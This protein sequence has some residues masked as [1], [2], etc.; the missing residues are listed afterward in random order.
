M[1]DKLFATDGNVEGLILRVVLA[2]VI[3]PHGAQK[4]L[5]WFGG[6]GWKGTLGFFKSLGIP[7]VFGVAAMLTEFLGPI[8]LLVGFA[9]KPVAVI[10]AVNMIVAA[11][12]VHRKTGFFM[13]W[14]GAQKGEGF[15]YHILAVGLALA[16]MFQGGG[17]LSVDR[18]LLRA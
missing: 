18:L 11:V 7:T 6:Y 5:G 10:I 12:M 8:A 1:L 3:V 4:V 13:N 15:E 14:S 16:V 2:L 17:M 9:T